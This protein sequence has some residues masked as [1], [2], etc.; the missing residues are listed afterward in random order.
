MSYIN[1]NKSDLQTRED[2]TKDTMLA[3]YDELL[4]KSRTNL[5]NS[6]NNITNLLEE[7]TRHLNI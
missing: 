2:I 7:L 6:D 5:S 4:R 1:D 3:Q